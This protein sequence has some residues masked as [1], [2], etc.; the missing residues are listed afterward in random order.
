MAYQNKKLQTK[1]HEILRRAHI[2]QS[3][4]DIAAELGIHPVTVGLILKSSLAKAE[5]AR[6]KTTDI[7]KTANTPARIR[8]VKEINEAAEKSLRYHLQVLNDEVIVD[9]KSKV[10]ISNLHV[11]EGI[12]K[13]EVSQDA[14]SFRD[15]IRGLSVVEQALEAGRN[16]RIID[17]TP[18]E[19]AS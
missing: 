5:L 1:H 9:E 10:R 3:N 11:A 12:Y 19:K 18:Q 14:T 15:I 6:M 2:G 8:L 7:E 4:K 13:T 17:I 16:S